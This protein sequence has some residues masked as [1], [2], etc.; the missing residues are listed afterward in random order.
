M[1]WVCCAVVRANWSREPARRRRASVA[2]R[3]LQFDLHL[4][5]HGIHGRCGSWNEEERIIEGAIARKHTEERTV[6]GLHVDQD[7]E[8]LG[9]LF[10]WSHRNI[11]HKVA[12]F[13]CHGIRLYSYHCWHKL[14]RGGSIDGQNLNAESAQS[15]CHRRHSRR[16]PS[17]IVS[18]RKRERSD[19]V[20]VISQAENEGAVWCHKRHYYKEIH[21]CCKAVSNHC[22]RGKL[23]RTRLERAHR[24]THG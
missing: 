24:C 4:N 9:S 8:R 11:L 20:S 6:A 2:A 1:Q 21:C 14:K 22:K 17:S 10:D 5:A 18:Q 13:L 23:A 16:C 7:N 15:I 3:V 19:T 12:H